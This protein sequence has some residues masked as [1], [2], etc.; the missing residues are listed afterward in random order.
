MPRKKAVKVNT[1]KEL[2]D[3]VRVAIVQFDYHPSAV[4]YYPLI[5]EPALL[6]EGEQGITSSHLTLPGFENRFIELRREVSGAYET[7]VCERVCNII[8]SLDK[9]NVQLVVFPEYSIP[10]NCLSAI[11]K[12]AN[13]L[14]VIAASHTVT[15]AS[16]KLV[17]KLGI[18]ASEQDDI[19]KSICPIRLNTGE[20]VR[21]DKLTKSKW[22][23]T[24]K[25]GSVWNPIVINPGEENEWAFAVFLCVDFI[26]ENDEHLAKIVPR[27]IWSQVNFGIV[28]S[29]SPI[30]RDFQ[31]RARPIAERAG[32][33]ILYSNV[34]SVGGS[35][36]YC[37]FAQQDV[38]IEEHATKPLNIEDEAVVVVDLNDQ[39]A[40]KPTRL[41]IQETSQFVTVLPILHEKNFEPFCNL[42]KKI[43]R[44]S[45]D[46]KKRAAIHESNQE[47]MSLA[48]SPSTPS[49]L[50]NKIFAFLS[51]VNYKDSQW[52]DNC[53]DCV[54]IKTDAVDLSELRFILLHKSQSLL[55]R[56]LNDVK[57][58][59]NQLDLVTE[60]L[61]VYRRYLDTLRP[62]I[63]QE[64]LRNYEATTVQMLNPDDDGEIFTSVFL[65]RL[66]SA[67]FH[68]ESLEKQIRLL[69]T[70]A[71]EGNENIALNLRY[72]SLPNPTGNLKTLEVDIIGAAKSNDRENSKQI[73]DT[74]RR[75]LVNLLRVTLRDA[76]SFRV[77]EIDTVT[78]LPIT[79]PFHFNHVATISRK[80]HY[81]TQPYIDKASAPVIYHLEGSSSFARI[82]DILQS[83][84]FA[85]MISVHL[86]PTKLTIAEQSFFQTY[87]RSE[88]YKAEAGEGA[89]FYLGA[90]ESKNPELRIPNAVTMRRLL[91]DAEGLVPNL[92]VRLLMASDV[93]LSPLLLN[94][95]GSELWGNDSYGIDYYN[96][97]TEEYD[98]MV[99]ILRV[100]WANEISTSA[101]VPTNLERIP[102]LFDVYEASRKFRLPLEGHSGTVGTLFTV[103]RAPAAVLPEE[104]IEI[105]LGFHSG[106]QK[107]LVVRLSD[108][109][110]TKHTYV[111][112][113]TGTG[114]STLLGRMI[115]QDI[116]RGDGVC[117]I[118]P[119]GDLIDAVLERIPESRID[120]VILFDPTATETP[121]GLNLL[122][123]SPDSP[124]H[125][126]FVVQETI[127]IIR[128]L[129]FFEHAGPV[130]EHNLRHLTLTMMDESLG[131]KGTLI[132]VPLL[133]TDRK[134][135]D[136]IVPNLK[137]ELAKEFWKQYK[138]I[139]DY[140]RGEQLFYVVSKFDTFTT[141][142]IMRNIIGQSHSTIN[143]ADILSSQK[144]LLVKLS[145]AVIG[146]INAALLGM[147]IISKLRWAGM[148]R[149]NISP[150]ERKDYFIYVDEFQNFATAGFEKILA[151][152]RKY[153]LSLTVSHQHIAQLNA[154]NISTGKI[155]D[156]VTQALFGN[157]GTMIVFRIGV[158]DTE[159]YFT[160]S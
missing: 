128:K 157:I 7:F 138:M 119:H 19:A 18:D 134:L 14:V 77:Q 83:S 38:F 102:Y 30:T 55:A 68:R 25:R 113:K 44:L 61:D 144:I 121:V 81:G 32:V 130:F 127:A 47:L 70:L 155:E 115:E 154:F 56:T 28:P 99:K 84:P 69:S 107:P 91:G 92:L 86:H 98:E 109:E 123:Y 34:A 101:E 90:D 152:A 60:I 39:A 31:Q 50:R 33:P 74:F 58:R 76:Y 97:N 100:V 20:W 151:E 149:A 45:K 13:N 4:L 132:E 136:S 66:S 118:D 146:E 135:R 133:L 72:T 43:K 2:T 41:P 114:K 37:Y 63:R 160:R 54:P 64:V 26:N 125:K 126:D 23:G 42:S 139:N 59:G 145:C 16:I 105:G 150:S 15:P 129:T 108:K 103:L 147:I 96:Q 51:G 11:D 93:P 122:E 106:A 48:S 62:H 95:V 36:I 143:I 40:T 52:L 57:L 46:E 12:I 158:K 94:T 1:K 82:L 79:E 124:H 140:H 27:N 110:R 80:V 35:R 73:A 137:D 148:S 85:C 5:E 53:V 29:Y 120:D 67:Q 116:E 88:K 9:L 153:G 142:R 8:K 111:I 78:L 3:F 49:I 159:D 117:V 87:R 104:G 21:I 75:D 17:K 156:R 141:D 65:L 131:G 10:V 71:Y 6:A 112:G 24:M 22:E 89:M